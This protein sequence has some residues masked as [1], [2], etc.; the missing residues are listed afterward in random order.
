MKKYKEPEFKVVM[1]KN[2]DVITTS[3]GGGSNKLN[4]VGGW[5][6]YGNGGVPIIEL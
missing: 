2:Q 6:A 5:E 1:T 3:G 4:R